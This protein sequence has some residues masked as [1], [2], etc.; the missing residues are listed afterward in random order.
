MKLNILVRGGGRRGRA[1]H[2]IRMLSVLQFQLEANL[3]WN[4]LS[5]FGDEL[6]TMTELL[7]YL[8]I[9]IS[10]FFSVIK[11]RTR[12]LILWEILRSNLN[13]FLTEL[14]ARLKKFKI[15][16]NNLEWNKKPFLHFYD[17][18]RNPDTSIYVVLSHFESF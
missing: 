10:G 14:W 11:M 13:F 7:K 18:R 1:E 8:L 9:L 5:W 2:T 17:L 16:L 15:E 3:N 6:L 12:I 4:D